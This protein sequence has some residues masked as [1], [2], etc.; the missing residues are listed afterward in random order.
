MNPFQS[1]TTYSPI[2]IKIL[3]PVLLYETVKDNLGVAF[4]QFA[5]IKYGGIFLPRDN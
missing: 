5:T 3:A 1:E 4:L 2:Y